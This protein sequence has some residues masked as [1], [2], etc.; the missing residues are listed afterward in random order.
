M[1]LNRPATAIERIQYFW[2]NP[3]YIMPTSRM[4]PN[5]TGTCTYTQGCTPGFSFT[6]TDGS[7]T[8]GFSHVAHE[9]QRF[10]VS[11]PER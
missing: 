8:N 4:C 1:G 9:P 7:Y 6:N 3:S 11:A 10:F 2:S 5:G